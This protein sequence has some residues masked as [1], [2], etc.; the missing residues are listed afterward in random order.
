MS[1]H[2]YLCSIPII[3]PAGPENETANALARAEEKREQDRAAIKGWELINDFEGGCLY[4]MSGWWSYS[5]CNNREIVQFHAASAAPNGQP[6]KR[7]P[8]SQEYVL[9]R[10][11]TLPEKADN[12]AQER[13]S[14]GRGGA[15]LPA[16]LQVKGEQ[17]YLVQR[18]EGGT[19]CDLTGRDRTIE[20]Q[21]QCA[22]GLQGDR[23]GWIKEVT[24]CSYVMMINTPR[25][26]NDVAFR[27]PPEKRANPITCQRISDGVPTLDGKV[28]EKK[29]SH[30]ASQEEGKDAVNSDTLDQSNPRPLIGDIEI[31]ARRILDGDSTKPPVKLAHPN[32]ILGG[33]LDRSQLAEVIAQAASKK[34]GGKVSQLSEED[35]AKL[36]IDPKALEDMR[37][38]LQKL[39]EDAGWTIEVVAVGDGDELELHGYVDEPEKPAGKDKTKDDGISGKGR[40]KKVKNG[41]SKDTDK[42]ND[43]GM[44]VGKR[45]KDEGDWDG[46]Q[47][48]TNGKK[49]KDGS[50]ETF[51]DEL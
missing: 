19:T 47:G 51:K 20:V 14:Q 23:I 6:P 22:P 33:G 28:T 4:Y 21:Y 45:K 25:L 38:E 39:A 17:R 13:S 48:E 11:P 8:H 10:I 42:G 26:C 32:D 50:E 29:A 30:D 7:D 15:D 44:P 3:Q 5:F 9:G 31:G 2:K 36:D 49:N 41:G 24:I 37:K 16:E 12:R 1:P 40:E 46:D 43:K 35:L 18:L 34:D 27:P